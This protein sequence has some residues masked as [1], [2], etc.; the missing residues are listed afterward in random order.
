MCPSVHWAETEQASRQGTAFCTVT[1]HFSSIVASE[2]NTY[3]KHGGVHWEEKEQASSA[4]LF[5]LNPLLPPS[6][7][8]LTIHFTALYYPIHFTAQQCRVHWSH[9]HY[10]CARWD[11]IFLQLNL[12]T[13][14]CIYICN[15][16]CICICIVV[17]CKCAGWGN[18]FLR[19]N[20]GFLPQIAVS[21]A[22][23]S[24]PHSSSSSSSSPSWWWWWW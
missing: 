3:E 1:V 23:A 22:T 21:P 8:L 17:Q 15:L 16:I 20:V 5:A 19:L 14:I 11:G 24:T 10:N 4:P 12:C 13:C 2:S 6:L 9:V 18:I 7:S